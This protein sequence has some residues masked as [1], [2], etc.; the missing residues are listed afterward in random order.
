MID[1]TLLQSISRVNRVAKGK[2]AEYIVDYIGITNHMKDALGVYSE[3]DLVIPD[4]MTD[5]R[6]EITRS[7]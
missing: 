5:V 7:I 6:T 1:H 2:E 3:H 4:V